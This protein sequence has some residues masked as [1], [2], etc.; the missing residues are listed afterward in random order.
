MA[1]YASGPVELSAFNLLLDKRAAAAVSAAVGNNKA[2][3]T[4]IYPLYAPE[5][6]EYK[7]YADAAPVRI[8]KAICLAEMAFPDYFPDYSQLSADE[9]RGMV[10]DA[11][12]A[13]NP[14]WW[15]TFGPGGG[16]A[17]LPRA[18]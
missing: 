4:T 18:L 11:I 6:L 7:S 2:W 9:R 1:A 8:A 16:P 15:G 3:P 14:G 12:L 5:L 10:S 17:R 13:P